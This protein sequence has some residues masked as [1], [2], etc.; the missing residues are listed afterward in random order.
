MRGFGAAKRAFE[1]LIAPTGI[2]LTESAE[3]YNAGNGPAILVHNPS[4]YSRVLRGKNLGFAESY[5]DG[6]CDLRKIDEIYY[7]AYEADLHR[8]LRLPLGQALDVLL[9]RL[10]NRQ[11]PR[12]TKRDTNAHYD[13][14]N[15]MF[16]LFLGDVPLYTCGYWHRDG[17]T[18]EEANC[19]AFDL[20]CRKLELKPGMELIDVGCGWG[21]LLEYAARNYR[22]KGL[23][24]NISE[25]QLNACRARCKGLPVDFLLQD[26]RLLDRRR[27]SEQ[28]DAISAIAMINHVGPKNYPQ[29]FATMHAVLKDR[30]L[31]VLQGIA[32]R[33]KMYTNDPFLDKYIFPGG[34][35]PSV[36]QLLESAEQYF[37]LEDFHNFT[38]YY[39]NTLRAWNANFQCNWARIS[40]LNFDERFR[41]MW[42][43]FL[44]SAAGTCRA[45]EVIIFQAV[46]S[47]G[48]CNRVY[49]APR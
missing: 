14:G 48:R 8:T 23:G 1:R 12:R 33:Q 28:F 10:V 40:A 13:L 4:F 6:W 24:V 11:A 49:T 16:G 18:L 25:P 3:V 19:A 36:A 27:F 30:G 17:M 15:E 35:C 34:V 7:R 20:T 43:I 45:R 2:L 46:F 29:F 47:K 22:I 42:E 26:C 38:S 37:T 41:R 9:A 32:N 44:L 39:P 5:M 21:A 31:F